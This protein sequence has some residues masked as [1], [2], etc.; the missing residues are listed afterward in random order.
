SPRKSGPVR[1]KVRFT[2]E[3][4]GLKLAWFGNV[5]ANPP[6]GRLLGD[7]V[8]KARSEFE[9]GNAKTVVLLIPARTDTIYWHEHIEGRAQMR[10]LK[11]RLRF[12]DGNG[13][14]DGKQPAPAPFPSA[15][16]IYGASDELDTLDRELRAW[17]ANGGT[18]RSPA[19][20]G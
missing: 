1:A 7:W 19:A 12:S 20:A 6:Y 11:G 14:S 18:T 16:V 5:F 17:R 3:D 13:N 10:F 9:A 15:L 4:D 8:A 2:A